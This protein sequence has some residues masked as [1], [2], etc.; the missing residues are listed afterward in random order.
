M[1][2]VLDVKS[3][4]LYGKIKEE[5]YV[6]QPPGFEDP[7][8]PDKV[9]KVKKA[10]Y[11]LHQAL[12]AWFTEVKTASTPMEIQKPLLKDEDGKEVKVHMY[13]SMIG[14]LMYRTSSRPNI[15]FAVC[16]FA[17][18][19]V[20][21]K[22]KKQ[23]VVANST[24][25]AEYVTA[26]SCY[27]QLLWIQNQLLDYG[28]LQ[29][30]DEQGVD[31]LP[32]S[33]IFEQ[34]ALMGVRKGFSRRV[35]PFFPTMVVQYEFG[36][37]SSM[38]TDPHHT[39]TILQSSSSQPQKIHKPRKPTRKVT[40]VPQPSDPMEH[41]ADE[42]VY[43]ELGDRLVKAATIASSLEAEQDNGNI[44]KTQSKATP[45]EPSSQGTNS[46]GGPSCQENIG[47]T[48][49]QT[50]FESIS[51]HSN[52]SLLARV[53]DLEKTKTTQSN[54]IASLKRTVKKVEKKNR[55]RTYKLKRLYK[56]SLTARVESFGDEE[57]LVEDASKQGR[58]KA[59]DKDEDIT[60]V[61]DQDD[62]DKDMLEVNILGGEEVFVAK[63]QVVNDVNENVVE[64]VVNAAQD[65]TATTTIT[66]E[67]ITL[68]QALKALKTSKPKV[69]G[70]VIQEQE[71]P[72]KST[73]TMTIT[74]PKQQSYDKGKG[75][76]I[77]EPVK[78][79]KK[80]QIKLDEEAAKR[81]FR[82][83][84]TFEA[85][86]SEFVEKKEKRVGKELIQESTKKQKVEDDKE[87]AKLKQLI[88]IIQ[89]KEE[90]E[91]NAIPLAVKSP[92]IVN[93]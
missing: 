23:T 5:M 56:V 93:W 25:E 12:R 86:I 26:L 1:G 72:G 87:T 16:A 88:E 34:L 27:G 21:P 22:C 60:L 74:I 73:T 57:S 84:N 35:T 80:D 24:I 59:I 68:A 38:P 15:M 49:T 47:D 54:E 30:A 77:E 7:N 48:T 28:D 37:G 19:Q 83:V 75:I 63:Q 78:P 79:K 66:T 41:V 11:G 45:N 4:F 62:V 81:A 14:S 69:K 50:W 42:A 61:N 6:C 9:Y 31:C 82:R 51:K 46:G 33:T 20:N 18:Y 70:I 53:L 71:E 76:M 10:L 92:R 90:V 91:I 13:R 2:G 64:E 89:D 44:N 39:P 29:L 58:I 17:R 40:Q 36:E 8:F 67:E 43:K 85:I 65:S 32:N 52:D 3:A 55:S